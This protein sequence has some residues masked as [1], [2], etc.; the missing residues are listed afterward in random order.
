MV[1][2]LS[3]GLNHFK[4]K[5]IIGDSNEWADESGIRKAN[6]DFVRNIFKP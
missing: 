4:S 1:K 6:A 3:F 5:I 2:K